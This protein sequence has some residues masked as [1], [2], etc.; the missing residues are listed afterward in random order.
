MKLNL[1]AD[2]V[3]TTTRAV[4][5]RL[6]FDGPVERA[7]VE[8]CP[9]IAFQAPTGSTSRRGTGS[10]SKTRLLPLLSS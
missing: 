4:R 2:E 9:E 1:G 7:V 10:W 3:L 8:E 5:K 6:D